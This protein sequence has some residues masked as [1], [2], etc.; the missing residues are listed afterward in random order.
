MDNFTSIAIKEDFPAFA[1]EVVVASGSYPLLMD[2]LNDYE[3]AC[4][5]MNDTQ[6]R[7]EDR[8]LWGEIRT[9]LAAE[10]RRLYLALMQDKNSN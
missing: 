9:E 8:A 5:G 10:I 2:A 7:V 3:R 6:A 1:D 4:A